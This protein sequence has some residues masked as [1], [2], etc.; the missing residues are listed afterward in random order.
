MRIWRKPPFP[1]PAVF[2]A[3]PKFGFLFL[4]LE[5]FLAEELSSAGGVFS[6]LSPGVLPMK[7]GR[8]D[9][10]PVTALTS[11]GAG[12]NTATVL[13]LWKNHASLLLLLAFLF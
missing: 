8:E 12:P 4:N 1:F 13:F 9:F 6:C 7:L 11:L 5:I 2:S 10:S 3:Y